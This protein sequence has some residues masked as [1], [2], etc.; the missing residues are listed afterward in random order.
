MS[1]PAKG[2]LHKGPV[3]CTQPI[4]T[5][6]LTGKTA[7]V[8]GGANGLGKGYVR[9]LVAEGVNVCIAD[10]NEEKGKE[11]EAELKG[12]KYIQCNTSIWE[13]QAR[14]F[15][16]A[17]SFSPTGRIHFVVANAG[18]HR[19]DEVFLCSSDEE[20]QK[21]DLSII[22]VNIQGTL[23]TVKLAAHYFIKQNGQES[24]LEQEDTCLVL[25]GSGAAFLDCP[26]APQY[27][28]SKWAI[29]GI[30]H[31]LRRTAFYYGSRVN[32]ISPW[33]VK[34][35]ILS[36]EAFAHVTNVG[37]RFAT[38]E[39][40]GHCLLR[41]LSD[42]SINGHSFFISGSKWAP[43]GYMDLD[44]EDYPDNELVQEI[45]EDQMKSAP[46]SMGLFV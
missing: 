2:Y 9:A 43:Q 17:V 1:Q 39:E 31:S 16:E 8:T 28:A 40:A 34:T 24:S 27:C 33:Y 3:D 22:D 11:L 36:E 41:I 42:T 44:L 20:P 15:R 26:R 19:S 21:P 7:I 38:V 6:S 10:L 23:Y 29:R 45:Q 5:R 32:V 37:V 13:D 12:T 46:V 25:I 30:L 18:I 35:N 14:L 4:D